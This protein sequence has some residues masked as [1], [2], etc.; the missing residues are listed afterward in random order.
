LHI[1]HVDGGGFTS[2]VFDELEEKGILRLEGPLGTFFVRNDQPQRPVIMMGG[3]TGFAPLKSM[4]EYMLHKNHHRSV[5][6]YWG[7]ANRAELYLDKLACQWAADH[8][9]ISYTPV[10]SDPLDRDGWSGRTGFVHRA[11]LEDFPALTEHDVYMSGPPVMIDAARH[12]FLEA[13][14]VE[15]RLYYDSFEYAPDVPVSVLAE[16]H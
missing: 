14:V 16:P 9:H 4:I 3:G 8:D 12:E 2:Y 11:V 5:H 13:G 1:R 10:L 7:A 15:R 6:L